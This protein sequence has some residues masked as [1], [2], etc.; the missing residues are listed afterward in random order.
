MYKADGKT[1]Q[2][3]TLVHQYADLVKKMAYQ[4]K[5]KLPASVEADDLIQAGMMGLLDAAGKYQDNQGAQ[6]KTY[7]TQRIHGAIMDEL[8][9]ADWLPR[10]VRKQMRDVE[11][12]IASLQQSLG[13]APSESEVAKKLKLDIADYFQMLTDC[14]GHQLIYFEDV[15]KGEEEDHFLDRFIQNNKSDVINGLL[16]KDFKEALKQSIDALPEREKMLMGLYYEQELN[17]KEIGAVMSVT[18]SRVSQM[19]SQA[20]AR[21]RATLKEKLWTGPA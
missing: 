20:V 5:A 21:I 18:E 16:S 12:A 6:F 9:N 4:I 10:N 13:R 2:K 8:R 17:L 11:K 15:H 7:A 1:D 3:E 19:H 14:S